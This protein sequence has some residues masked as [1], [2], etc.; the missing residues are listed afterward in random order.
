MGDYAGER[1]LIYRSGG[2]GRFT[3][4]CRIINTKTG[5]EFNLRKFFRTDKL[6]DLQNVMSK[7]LKKNNPQ[8]IL[9]PELMPEGLTEQ[10]LSSVYS[11]FCLMKDDLIEGEGLIVLISPHGRVQPAVLLKKEHLKEFFSPNP[12]INLLMA[13]LAK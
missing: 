1:T 11:P 7:E 8:F 2:S 10:T 5:K 9:D 12:L 4:D 13:A 3:S 6:I